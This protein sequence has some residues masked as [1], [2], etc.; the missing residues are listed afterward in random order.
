MFLSVDLGSTHFKAGIF[1]SE[2]KLLG[3][4]AHLL[5]HSYPEPGAVELSV[6]E[7]TSAFKGTIGKALLKSGIRPQLL[8][9]VAITSQAQ[10]STIVDGRG[11]PKIPF[12][13]WQD[14][15]ALSC[16]Q[17]M[18]KTGQ[19]QD[20][21]NHA[22]FGDL[23]PGLQVCILQHLLETEKNII[24]KGDRLLLLPS[25]L[26]WLLSE[27]YC[28][29]NN[30]AA[31]S[32]LFSFKEADWWEDALV[33]FGLEARQLPQ[34]S[35]IG[36]TAVET[37]ERARSFGLREGIPIVLAGN[38]QTAGAYGAEIHR[39]RSLLITLGTAHAVYSVCQ[40]MPDPSVEIV[41]GNYPYGYYYKMGADNCGGNVVNW[42]V[43]LL[44]SDLRHDVFFGLASKAPRGC[45]GL[46]FQPEIAARQGCW[47]NIGLHHT[48]A[49]FARSVLESLAHRLETMVLTIRGQIENKR[50]VVAGGG[51]RHQ[52][53]LDI[54][55]QEIGTPVVRTE[56]DPLLGAARM[57][58]EAIR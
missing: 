52:L 18:K 46:T 40:D 7:V 43:R 2:L 12:I 10:T 31:M 27:S 25:Y 36:T 16:C 53:W 20:F 44:L 19:W 29:D 33:F 42:A 37:D 5:H 6:E 14:E 54:L 21:K 58:R 17:Q 1:D 34:V 35:E 49:D 32:G 45:N 28:I 13:S 4:G 30:L 48:K 11:N 57:A 50:V 9:A 22:S 47:Q 55:T 41:R 24:E 8:K 39:D 38:D 51:S 3:S 15:R 26:V 23:L 56:A